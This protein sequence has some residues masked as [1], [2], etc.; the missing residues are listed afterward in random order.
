MKKRH[1]RLFLVLGVVAGVSVA[2]ALVLN[3][4][5]D[6]MTFFITPSEVM[7]KSDMPERHFRIGGL[8]EDGSVERDSASTRVRFHV[9]DTEASVPVDFEGI[10]PDLFR[11]GQG[12]VVEGRIT[13]DGVF[14][15]DNVMARHDEDYMPAEAQEA[16][17]RVEHSFDEAGDY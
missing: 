5:R 2:T 6:N 4:F 12:V 3:A 1:Q 17:D 11:E 14:K 13:S 10:L 8:V 9:T 7:A 15:A 16:L